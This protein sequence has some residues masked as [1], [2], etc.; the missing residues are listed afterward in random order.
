MARWVRA[1]IARRGKN[2]AIVALANKLSRVAW[3]VLAQNLHYEPNK[4]FSSK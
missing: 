4:A 3:V 1:L 2:K